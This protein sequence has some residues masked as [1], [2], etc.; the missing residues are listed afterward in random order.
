[1]EENTLHPDGWPLDFYTLNREYARSTMT[2]NV[3]RDMCEVYGVQ[4]PSD[5]FYEAGG[6][7]F[8]NDCGEAITS[9]MSGLNR[10]QLHILS[11]AEAILENVWVDLT[12]AETDEEWKTIQAETIKKL[13]DLGEPEVFKDFQ[14]KWNDAAEII[15]PLVQQAQ[16]RNGIE[17]YTPEDYAERIKGSTEEQKP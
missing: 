4:L 3:S 10:D 1:L 12:L 2:S 9:C 5:A 8:R 15:V 13:I 6:L 17:P 16:I 7:D 14:K 11:K